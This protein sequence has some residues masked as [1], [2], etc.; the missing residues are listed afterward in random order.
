MNR[1]AALVL[2]ISVALMLFA[3]VTIMYLNVRNA[4]HS[5]ARIVLSGRCRQL[6]MN[7]RQPEDDPTRMEHVRTECLALFP[8][9]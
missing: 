6:A 5:V 9:D 2:V 7:V 3:L 4:D 1:K 8:A